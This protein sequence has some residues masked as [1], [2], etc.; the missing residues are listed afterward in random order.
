MS[1]SIDPSQK[2][3]MVTIRISFKV[4]FKVLS[5]LCYIKLSSWL[6]SQRKNS[7]IKSCVQGPF[8]PSLP[9]ISLNFMLWPI[10][11]ILTLNNIQNSINF[12]QHS[13]M[14]GMRSSTILNNLI[15]TIKSRNCKK[16]AWFHLMLSEV[17]EFRCSLF[18]S[19]SSSSF[20]EINAH[21][22]HQFCWFRSKEWNFRICSKS[23]NKSLHRFKNI[24][25]PMCKGITESKNMNSP[26]Y[27]V[28]VIKFIHI[29]PNK[30]M[31]FP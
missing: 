30:F 8:F 13:R 19:E 6:L 3:I 1:W 23:A 20:N 21:F 17:H 2:E 24:W 4:I 7:N 27:Y 28:I 22:L 31:M 26:C 5:S 16:I 12:Q 25:E 14:A 15:K 9:I 29:F 10:P 18:P 11:S